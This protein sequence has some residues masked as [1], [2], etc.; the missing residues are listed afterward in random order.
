M[1]LFFV[2]ILRSEARK[3]HRIGTR[4]V[5]QDAGVLRFAQDEDEKPYAKCRTQSLGLAG[6]SMRA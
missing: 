4:T 1:S 5:F 6:A 2:V 3:D